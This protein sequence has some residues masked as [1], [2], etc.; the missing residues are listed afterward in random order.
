[1]RIDVL[2]DE[3]FS[4]K[5]L[6]SHLA[7]EIEGIAYEFEILSFTEAIV[8][9]NNL[10]ALERAID[11][12]RFD[13]G[14]ITTFYNENMKVLLRLPPLTLFKVALSDLQPAQ[15]YCSQDKIVRVASF[16]E[17]EEDIVVPVMEYNDRFVLCDGHARCYLASRSGYDEIY[18]YLLPF[19]K[20]LALFANGCEKENITQV[21]QMIV[22]EEDQFQESWNDFCQRLLLQ[23][24][25]K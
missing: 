9:T 22:L 25:K 12:F 16:I 13:Q 1:M 6:K 18:A 11:E 21:D 17:S 10:D 4:S 5:A 3:R 20:G 23:I 15:P 14:N 24:T 8:R 2:N 19:E 7:Y